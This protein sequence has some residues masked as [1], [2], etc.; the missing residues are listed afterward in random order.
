MRKFL[1]LFVLLALLFSLCACNAEVQNESDPATSSGNV[2]FTNGSD[3]QTQNEEETKRHGLKNLTSTN[4]AYCCT[5]EGYYYVPEEF[6]ELA[7]GSWGTHIMYMDFATNQ[8][9]YLCSDVGCSHDNK[10]CSA[11]LSE[12][13][14]SP[15]S[16]KIFAWNGKLYL[17]DKDA[18][19][20]GST[21]IDLM[22]GQNMQAVQAE[23][24][25]ATLYQMNLDGSDRKKIYTFADGIT[26]EDTI[27]SSND[28]IYFITKK[29]ET[30]IDG[31][32]TVTTS[33]D[34]NI[35]RFSPANK[36]LKTIMPLQTDDGISWRIVGC[37]DNSLVLEGIKY[38]NGNSGSADMS[39]AEWK[40]LY[41]KSQTVFATLDL[42][43]QKHT[44]VY[45]VKNKGLHA[46]ATHNGFLYVSEASSK[47]IIAIDLRNGNTSTLASLTQNNIMGVFSD[48]L[49]CQTW[50]LTDDYTLYF[51]STKDGQV[52]HCTLT[53]KCNGWPLEVI[54]QAGNDALVIYD[55]KADANSD[56]SY[57]IHQYKYALIA[58]EDL[59]AG[60]DT[61]RPIEMIGKGR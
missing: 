20:D 17:L 11:V 38:E 37:Y 7:D 16:G 30:D 44:D 10:S 13:E 32:T 15:Y 46:S 61:F 57:E 24:R 3:G 60:K 53:N 58:K 5:Q 43:S 31:N 19:R 45:Q 1:N 25:P 8:E 12:D 34:R 14:Y 27:L 21:T 51:V 18:D 40:E 33:T 56:G 29:L 54:C 42:S 47:D 48:M 6:V 9:V 39:D 35:V 52:S 59:Y 50:D 22:L 26:L 41:N 23:T 55:Y 4:Y 28:G 36:Q 2:G 49:I